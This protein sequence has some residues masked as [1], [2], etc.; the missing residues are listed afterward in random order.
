MAPVYYETIGLGVSDKVQLSAFEVAWV[1]SHVNNCSNGD[2]TSAGV[3]QQISKYWGSYADRTSVAIATDNYL[4]AAVEVEQHCPSCT[5]AEIAQRVQ[6]SK[7]P[8]RYAAAQSIVEN[9][10]DEVSGD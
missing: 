2:G 5:A 9:I 1:E 4:N 8:T 3:F 10:L 7:Y 6:R